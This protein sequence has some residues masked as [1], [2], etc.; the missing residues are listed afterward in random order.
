MHLVEDWFLSGNVLRYKHNKLILSK[1]SKIKKKCYI[2][3]AEKNVIIYML[4]IIRDLTPIV[5]PLCKLI[6]GNSDEW[7]KSL[8]V[9]QRLSEIYTHSFILMDKSILF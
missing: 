6:F 4:G 9:P 3:L 8:K 1:Y 5:L 2:L 7:W